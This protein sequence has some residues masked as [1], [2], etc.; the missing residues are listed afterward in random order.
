M[1]AKSEQNQNQTIKYPVCPKQGFHEGEPLNHLCLNNQCKSDNIIC[2]F[3][4]EERHKQH[5]T[6]PLKV[7]F[8]QTNQKIK[9]S[10][11]Q[12]QEPDQKIDIDN[13]VQ[14]LEDQKKNMQTVFQNQVQEWNKKF[15]EVEQSIIDYYDLLKESAQTQASSFQD[16][17]QFIDQIYTVQYTPESLSQT[18]F[19]LLT[20]AP[21]SSEKIQQVTTKSINDKLL[22][23]SKI[24]QDMINTKITSVSSILNELQS[25]KLTQQLIATT[26]KQ[27]SQN[28]EEVN[29]LFDKLKHAKIQVISDVQVKSLDI[30]YKMALLEPKLDLSKSCKFGFK[31]IKNPQN[32]L[33][34]GICDKNVVEKNKFIFRASPNNHGCYMVA[35]NKQTLSC[36]S[37]DYNNFPKGFSFLEGDI[38]I[39]EFNPKEKKT[40]FSKKNSSEKVELAM[41]I[42]DKQQLH[43]CCL[44]QYKESEPYLSILIY[45]DLYNMKAQ[46]KNQNVCE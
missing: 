6:M 44:L 19:K 14:N 22:N 17:Q 15:Q 30:S 36:H 18:I 23:E 33:A 2:S 31:I 9:E 29:F 5:Q 38:V 39:V 10:K 43:A 28:Q 1:E 12:Q 41:N 7:F 13:I 25:K 4:I 42:S 35:S 16:I 34:V 3:C 40:I 20:I 37:S 8:H 24:F 26:S 46:Q 21:N 27:N 45:T 32:Y 11:K